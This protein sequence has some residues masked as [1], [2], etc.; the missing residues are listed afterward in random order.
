MNHGTSLGM[1][2]GVLVALGLGGATAGCGFGPGDYAI[3]QVALEEQSRS[4]GCYYP[5]Q[6]PSPNEMFDSSDLVSTDTWILTAGPNDQFYLS[7][8]VADLAG[9]E[10]DDGYKFSAS[11]VD[12]DFDGNV[13]TGTKR[14]EWRTLD[15]NVIVDGKAISGDSV[16]TTSYECV[17]TTC[18]APIPSCTVTTSFTGA[19]I[20]DVDLEHDPA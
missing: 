16:S 3:F 9:V 4:S 7:S 8:N 14:T 10:T 13:T 6:G 20:D 17:G 1:R 12:V 18:G 2:L 15:V 5:D 11:S 19:E